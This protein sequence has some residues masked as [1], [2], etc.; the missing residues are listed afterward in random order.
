MTR[1]EPPI[2]VKLAKAGDNVQSILVLAY[3]PVPP[4]GQ[5][6]SA[7]HPAELSIHLTSYF[8]PV[9]ASIRPVRPQKH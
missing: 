3:D 2:I 8:G 5:V 4:R 7:L 6:M 1:S 9:V